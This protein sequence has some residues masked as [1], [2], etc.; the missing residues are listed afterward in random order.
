MGIDDWSLQDEITM[1]MFDL[2]SWE[3]KKRDAERMV[4]YFK[5]KLEFLKKAQK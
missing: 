4:N 3:I 2:D 1:V 5:Q